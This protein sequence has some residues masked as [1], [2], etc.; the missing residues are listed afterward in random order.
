MSFNAAGMCGTDLGLAHTIRAIRAAAG[1]TN[2]VPNQV[3]SHVPSGNAPPP[4]P[5]QSAAQNTNT[6]GGGNQADDLS[7]ASGLTDAEVNQRV[8]QW[9]ALARQRA[10]NAQHPSLDFP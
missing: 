8:S 4:A 6:G 7:Q 1:T 9:T 5:T 10:F 3:P 2:Q